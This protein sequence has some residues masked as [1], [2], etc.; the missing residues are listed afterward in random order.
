MGTQKQISFLRIKKMKKLLILFLRASAF[1]VQNDELSLAAIWN[2]INFE[3][4]S[5]RIRAVPFQSEL[6]IRLLS[7]CLICPEF[8]LRVVS[9]RQILNR[10][11][12]LHVSSESSDTFIRKSVEVKL[13]QFDQ[14]G[15]TI[16]STG[17]DVAL[18]YRSDRSIS[19]YINSR[20]LED[21]KLKFPTQSILKIMASN[22]GGTVKILHVKSREKYGFK[23]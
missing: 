21:I 8:V 22:P 15:D 17:L 18:K 2:E 12:K 7:S 19:V 3:H 20:F 14:L 5:Y 10:K 9:E 11:L 4:D 13:D 6:E 1:F 16:Y 23:S